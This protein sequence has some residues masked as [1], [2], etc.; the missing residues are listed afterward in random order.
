VQNAPV[1]YGAPTESMSV[2][3]SDLQRWIGVPFPGGVWGTFVR[4]IFF[5]HPNPLQK[6]GEPTSISV[7]RRCWR[8]FIL[9]EFDKGGDHESWVSV[10]STEKLRNFNK[11]RACPL[12]EGTRM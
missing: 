2:A 8:K 3:S 7:G 9:V 4:T 1:V 12:N 11:T 5:P 10:R 6:V